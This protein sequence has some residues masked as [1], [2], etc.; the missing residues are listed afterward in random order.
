MYSIGVLKKADIH[1]V[2]KIT[3]QSM[4]K[5]Y[6]LISKIYEENVSSAKDMLSHQYP[7]SPQVQQDSVMIPK[8]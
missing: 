6:L 5:Y 8:K 7:I 3:K 2:I 1:Q 4:K